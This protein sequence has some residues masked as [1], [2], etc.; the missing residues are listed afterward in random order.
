MAHDIV[1]EITT[2]TNTDIGEETI[3]EGASM[4]FS[5]VGTTSGTVTVQ[6]RLPRKPST[7]LVPGVLINVTDDL[8]AAVTIDTFPTT[9]N[10]RVGAGADISVK[11]EGLVDGTMTVTSLPLKASK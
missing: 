5:F 7:P 6:K 2:N 8:G 4:S 3:G 9:L 10:I 1:K 11:T